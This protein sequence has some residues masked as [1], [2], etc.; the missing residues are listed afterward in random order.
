LALDFIYG[1]TYELPAAVIS[2]YIA[3][4][5]ILVIT[6]KSKELY[7]LQKQKKRKRKQLKPK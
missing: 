2:A 1:V 7:S 3:V 6:R 5:T 4:L